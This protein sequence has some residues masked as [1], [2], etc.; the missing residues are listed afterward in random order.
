MKPIVKM[1]KGIRIETDETNVDEVQAD[2]D[3]LMNTTGNSSFLD[4]CIFQKCVIKKILYYKS[5]KHIKA[6]DEEY[7]R[8]NEGKTL[9]D[10]IKLAYSFSIES[11]NIFT[12]IRLFALNGSQYYAWALRKSMKGLGTMD[13][14]LIHIVIRR[15]EVIDASIKF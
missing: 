4:G 2:V 8:R 3:D 7:G 5:F 15:C 10:A 13:H 1:L 14:L 11:D 12:C 9:L 6:V